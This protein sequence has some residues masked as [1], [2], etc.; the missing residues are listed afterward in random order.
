MKESNGR[1]GE[2]SQPLHCSLSANFDECSIL[3][4]IFFV[5]SD[6]NGS[7]KTKWEEEFLTYFPISPCQI[8][9]PTPN[10]DDIKPLSEN[11]ERQLLSA[12]P[13][14][15]LFAGDSIPRFDLVLLDVEE[16][17]ESARLFVKNYH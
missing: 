15:G 5:D 4:E 10:D 3:R 2:H 16:Q 7:T 12:F 17:G 11:Y 1:N 13:G 8:H 14:V 9:L 6:V